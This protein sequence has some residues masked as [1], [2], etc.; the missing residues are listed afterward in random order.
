[1][2]AKIQQVVSALGRVGLFMLAVVPAWLTAEWL[3]FGELWHPSFPGVRLWL[4]WSVIY[5]AFYFLFSAVIDNVK[6]KFSGS[7]E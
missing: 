7:K 4:A 5:A 6:M 1:M 3:M 2:N